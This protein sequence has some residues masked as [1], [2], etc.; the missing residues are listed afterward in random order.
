MIWRAGNGPLYFYWFTILGSG[1]PQSGD[2]GRLGLYIG[3]SDS[4]D[5]Y[6]TY[7]IITKCVIMSAML[8]LDS[9]G[10][11]VLPLLLIDI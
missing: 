5:L 10:F 1:R 6:E 8:C 11:S 2:N 7:T 4:M 3:N 9:A